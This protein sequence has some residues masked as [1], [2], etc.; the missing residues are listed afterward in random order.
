MVGIA[1]QILAGRHCAVDLSPASKRLRAHANAQARWVLW[2]KSDRRLAIRVRILRLRP[3]DRA[4][5][6][7][8]VQRD[9]WL[10]STDLANPTCG[11]AFL[12]LTV[13]GALARDHVPLMRTQ[14]TRGFREATFPKLVGRIHAGKCS[15]AEPGTLAKDGIRIRGG[16][17]RTSRHTA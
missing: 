4:A 9:E 7:Q 17:D 3:L 15:S 13:W 12:C 6:D 1:E 16:E 10:L 14:L 2:K 11:A 8:H 5:C